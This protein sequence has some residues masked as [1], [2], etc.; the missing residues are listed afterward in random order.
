MRGAG[1]RG[2]GMRGSDYRP[3][4]PLPGGWGPEGEPSRLAGHRP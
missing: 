2:K 4:V 1:V 3:S